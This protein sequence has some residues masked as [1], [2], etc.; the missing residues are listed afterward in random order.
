MSPP[1]SRFRHTRPLLMLHSTTWPSVSML[2]SGWLSARHS[3]RVMYSGRRQIFS[4]LLTMLPKVSAS[5]PWGPGDGK[6][7]S[8]HLV[9]VHC[10][11]Q[12]MVTAGET[13]CVPVVMLVVGYACTELAVLCRV[14]DER[15][16]VVQVSCVWVPGSSRVEYVVSDITGCVVLLHTSTSSQHSIRIS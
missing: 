3:S 16:P 4:L 1:W 6:S 15:I 11:W 2:T 9:H 13:E 8:N 5:P 10:G 14:G 12:G 7:T